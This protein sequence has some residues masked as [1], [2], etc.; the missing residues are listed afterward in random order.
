M[1]EHAFANVGTAAIK[2][3]VEKRKKFDSK[4]KVAEEKKL[5]T[6]SENTEKTKRAPNCKKPNIYL[7]VMMEWE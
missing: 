2:R 5:A 1:K 7:P 4:K 3:E 6:E